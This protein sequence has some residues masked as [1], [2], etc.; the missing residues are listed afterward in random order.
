M[1][2]YNEESIVI[3]TVSKYE[4]AGRHRARVITMDGAIDS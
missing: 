2:N 3:V 1:P 4:A